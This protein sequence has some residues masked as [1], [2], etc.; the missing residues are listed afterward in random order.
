[1]LKINRF[2]Y[3]LNFIVGHRSE[4][5]NIGTGWAGQIKGGGFRGEFLC[6]LPDSQIAL[7]SSELLAAISGDYTFTNSLYLHME[8]LYNSQGCSSHAGG[9]HLIEAF[10]NQWLTPAKFS[11]FAHIARNLHPLL[12]VDISGIINPNDRSWYLGPSLYYSMKTNLDLVLSGL[13]FGGDTGSEFGDNG[14]ML[15]AR[16]K[17]SF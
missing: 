7:N 10:L 6:S 4:E 5:I 16:W 9:E 2:D 17:W 11:I 13:T 8:F 1:L 3:D 12:R 15:M 14:E